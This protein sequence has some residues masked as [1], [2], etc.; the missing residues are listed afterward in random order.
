MREEVGVKEIG[1]EVGFDDYCQLNGLF[2]K[3][4]GVSG[5]EQGGV[6]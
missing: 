5:E 6:Y 4:R 2:K 1:F 3:R